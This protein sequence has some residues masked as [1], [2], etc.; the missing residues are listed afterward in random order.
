MDLKFGRL[1]ENYVEYNAPDLKR[2]L[3]VEF[4]EGTFF[5]KH[6][7]HRDLREMSSIWKH[8]LLLVVV[9]VAVVVVVVVVVVVGTWAGH[10]WKT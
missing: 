6:R 3:G 9:V 5:R 1:A 8:V 2:R 7:Y 10:F 4:P